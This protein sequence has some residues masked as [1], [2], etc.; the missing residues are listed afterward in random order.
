M[1]SVALKSISAAVAVAILPISLHLHAQNV[2]SGTGQIH[3]SVINL[4]TLGG[5]ESN[6]YGGVNNR[7]WVTGDANLAGDQNEHAF[8]WREGVMTDLGTLGGLNSSIPYP[9]KDD[10]GLVVGVAQTA[11]VDLL[12]EFWGATF[13]CTP[14]VSCQ[15]WQNLLRGF[16]WENGV[17]TAVPTL[18]GNNN[19]A[20]GVN[21]RGQ[22]VGAAET[23]NQDPNCVPP[24]VLDIEAVVWGPNPGQIEVLPVFPG[25]SV[26]VALAINDQGQVVGTSGPCQGPLSGLAFRH[27]VL[28]Q[29]DTVTD[30]GSLGGVTSNAANAI[31]NLGQVV[32]QSDLPGDTATHAFFWQN[33][34]MTDFGTLPGDSNSMAFDI[35]DKGQVLGVSCDVNFNC[36]PFLWEDGVMTDLNTLIPPNSPLYL[37]YGSGINDRGEITGT[38]CVTSNG[39][40]TSEVPAFLA[41][42][43]DDAHTSFEA[44]ADAATGAPLAAQATG[45]RTSIILP[46]SIRQHL[47]RPRGFGRFA[48]RPVKQ[49]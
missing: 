48:V 33:G 2:P 15:G 14:S 42:P 8:L 17:M 24:Q 46:E 43:C 19:A 45:Q 49:Q 21:N 4:G 3:Y 29:R 36:R 44:C 7:G 6:G 22:I 41:V 13:V 16:L 26:A 34:V 32:G 37:T 5:T 10:S 9:T 18:G 23:T 12:G 25:D 47:Q 30:L 20:L 27:A 38:A 31:N 40:C 11:T 1:K 35:N 28:W 39:V